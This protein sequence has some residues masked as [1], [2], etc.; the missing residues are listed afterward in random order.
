MGQQPSSILD[1]TAAANYNGGVCWTQPCIISLL[2]TLL[3]H[4]SQFHAPTISWGARRTAC[5]VL[6]ACYNP[7]SC[8]QEPGAGARGRSQAC[9]QLVCLTFV[10]PPSHSLN[11]GLQKQQP[12]CTQ[13][14][15]SLPW[16]TAIKQS[17][18]YTNMTHYLIKHT[19]SLFQGTDD[20]MSY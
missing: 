14:P 11:V 20:G 1:C 4:T 13:H 7:T 18:V 10:P 8:L 9:R 2:H 3:S 5:W 6:A 12:A 15:P 16:H 17:R 19:T